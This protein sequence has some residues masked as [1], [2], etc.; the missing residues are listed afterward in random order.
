MCGDEDAAAWLWCL[1]RTPGVSGREELRRRHERS[2]A[3][4]EV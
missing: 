4:E 2:D 1:A 3:I